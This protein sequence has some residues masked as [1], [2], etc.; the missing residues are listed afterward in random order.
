MSRNATQ[1]NDNEITKYNEKQVESPGED[2]GALIGKVILLGLVLVLVITSINLGVGAVRNQDQYPLE[3][4]N[5]IYSQETSN[6]EPVANK[7]KVKAINVDIVKLST[8]TLIFA[9]RLQ[10]TLSD[11]NYAELSSVEEDFSDYKLIDKDKNLYERI[12]LWSKATIPVVEMHPNV[13]VSVNGVEIKK[14]SKGDIN[15]FISE[16]IKMKLRRDSSICEINLVAPNKDLTLIKIRG[17]PRC[18]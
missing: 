15:A 3:N 18:T 9:E 13:L 16:V 6:V 4:N 17:T 12:N 14:I 8:L 1:L 11:N 2:R 10:K 5:R 7:T